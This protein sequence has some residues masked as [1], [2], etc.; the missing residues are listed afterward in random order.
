[1]HGVERGEGSGLLHH[2]ITVSYDEAKDKDSIDRYWDKRPQHIW[3][4]VI[5]RLF[6]VEISIHFDTGS[7][8][9]HWDLQ[10]ADSCR[11]PCT[12][13]GVSLSWCSD[14]NYCHLWE[15]SE[16][17]TSIMRPSDHSAVMNAAPLFSVVCYFSGNSC[18]VGAEK[19]PECHFAAFSNTTIGDSPQNPYSN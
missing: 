14:Q 18:P 13:P 12:I 7:L 4:F 3:T 10:K 11:L 8:Y 17:C 6:L 1:M 16:S 15:T 19:D 9:E 2:N 5:S